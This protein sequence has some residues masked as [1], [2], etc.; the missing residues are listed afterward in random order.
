MMPT[1]TLA[2]IPICALVFIAMLAIQ[3]MIPPT[4]MTVSKPMGLPPLAG[5]GC[6]REARRALTEVRA[7]V[8]MAPLWV[9]S[10]LIRRS[11]GAAVPS[12]RLG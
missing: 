4:M 8:Q 7:E 2:I 9:L 5:C 12:P 10:H 6:E 3:P 1:T 11:T